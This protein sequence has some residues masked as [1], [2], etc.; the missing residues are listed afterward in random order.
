MATGTTKSFITSHYSSFLTLDIY[1]Q[2]EFG[3]VTICLKSTLNQWTKSICWS[4]SNLTIKTPERR[5]MTSL[6]CLYSLL[7][8]TLMQV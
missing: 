5:E 7:K 3:V 2:S 6:C 8:D 1:F 4:G